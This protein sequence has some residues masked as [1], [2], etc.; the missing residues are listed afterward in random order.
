MLNESQYSSS[1]K[2]EARIYLNKKFKT[3]PESKYTWIF[4]HFPQK[5]NLRVLEIGC[6][7]GLFWF[8]NQSDIKNS[9]EIVLSDY[10]E[11]MLK[12]A[13]KS[14]SGV[15]ID[16]KYEVINAE[17]I[18]LGN[19]TFDVILAN[20][21]L[22]HIQNRDEAIKN[23]HRILNK[24]GTFIASTMGKNDHLELHNYLHEF[25]R[26]KGINFKFKEFSFSMNNGKEQLAKY[27]NDIT[28]ENYDNELKIDEVDPI[29]N[30][31]MSFNGMY[32]NFDVL[33]EKYV[34]EF[35]EY[36]REI[37]SKEKIIETRREEGMFICKK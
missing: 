7:T 9:W 22:Y 37:I 3:N 21:M 5:E 1:E 15:N 34:N 11:G 18:N 8:A 27:F 28:I 2:Y 19:N 10:S 12:T 35:R 20:N 32:G 16:F 29:I 33:P 14:L 4:K 23:I 36:L 31:Y 6:G 24:N 13:K 30:Y 17:D 25:L 26:K